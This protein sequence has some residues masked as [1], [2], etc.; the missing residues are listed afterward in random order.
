MKKKEDMKKMLKEG[1][2]IKTPKIGIDL[3][4]YEI[5]IAELTQ[6]KEKMSVG[7][8]LKFKSEGRVGDKSYFKSLKNNIKVFADYYGYEKLE[9]Y[10][11]VSPNI[12]SVTNTKVLTLPSIEKKI[13][14]KAIKFE[15][16]EQ[17]IV[18]NLANHHYMWDVLSEVDAEHSIEG[19]EE[20]KVLLTTIRRDFIYE[21]AQL[22]SIN[23]K[24]NRVELQSSVNGRRVEGNAVVLD[25][26]HES[27]S[28]SI[29][30]DGRLHEFEELDYS[31]LKLNNSLQM[32][33]ESINYQT[34]DKLIR[35]S[36]VYIDKELG[37]E[38]IYGDLA[39]RASETMTNEANA[40]ISEIKRIVRGF[41]LRNPMKIVEIDNIYYTGA[42]MKVKGL[43]KLLK[44]N[45]DYPVVPLYDSLNLSHNI[46]GTEEYDVL[47]LPS[48]LETNKK[49]VS[50]KELIKE[51]LSE[52]KGNVNKT[53]DSFIDLLG[54]YKKEVDEKKVDDTGKE[55]KS[56]SEYEEDEDKILSEE[57]E[58]ISEDNKDDVI[59]FAPSLLAI[60]DGDNE[61]DLDYHKYL[62]Y[63]FDF[64]SI[65]IMSTAMALTLTLGLGPIDKAYSDKI[66]D[67]NSS[68]QNQNADIGDLESNRS[69]LE[70]KKSENK[71]LSERVDSLKNEKKWFSEV[72]YEIPEIT[73]KEVI[74]EHININN[75]VVSIEGYSK[76]YTDIGAFAIGLESLG[77]Y[78]IKEI[79]DVDASDKLVEKGLETDE[80]KESETMT[81]QFRMT[82]KK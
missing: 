16:V 60:L 28:I 58:L 54:K 52:L 18:D 32:I 43:T 15:A 6:N 59:Y 9:I 20:S 30:E 25:F 68:L 7:P 76:D 35:K 48:R 56:E 53:K 27:S 2:I 1:M 46:K 47:S 63:K 49:D 24:V 50:N 79:Q 42:G 13:L 77:E 70:I 44:D 4:S 66:S 57:K 72:L 3:G 23:W 69:E 10:F 19:T 8:S 17:G 71:E 38:P 37:I 81:K 67:L 11:T 31:G 34:A 45:F 22:R 21:I 75:G 51:R 39:I 33:G 80:R 65:L 73:P 29:Y 74:V 12:P 82:L 5:K 40:I 55:V 14:E 62:K 64:S 41:E 61:L 78:E 36:N 26:G